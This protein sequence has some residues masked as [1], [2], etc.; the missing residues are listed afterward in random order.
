[1]VVVAPAVV[2]SSEGKA[3]A[4]WQKALPKQGSMGGRGEGKEFV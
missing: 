1:M 2:V 3:K 4:C